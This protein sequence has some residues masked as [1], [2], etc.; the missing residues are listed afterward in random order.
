V[1]WGGM[2]SRMVMVFRKGAVSGA[3]TRRGVVHPVAFG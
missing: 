1:V 3:S 2:E